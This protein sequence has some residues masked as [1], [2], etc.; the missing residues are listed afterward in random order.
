MTVL[1]KAIA[2]ASRHPLKVLAFSAGA[3]VL[4]LLLSLIMGGGN[5]KTGNQQ[6][7]APSEAAV[8]ESS[9]GSSETQMSP[10]V[11]AAYEQY[12]KDATAKGVE[13]RDFHFDGT[14]ESR[15]EALRYVQG[16]MGLYSLPYKG[17]TISAQYIDLAPDGRYLIEV[18]YTSSLGAAKQE[19][20]GYLRKHKDSGSTYFVVYKKS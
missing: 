18:K 20:A 15:K 4:V 3:L 16:Q 1:E 11:A 12:K 17:K 9:T 14:R 10:Q 6:T 5:K 19:W 7:N 13:P 2:Y 8:T